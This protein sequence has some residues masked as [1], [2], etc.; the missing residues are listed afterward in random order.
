MLG[1][2]RKAGWSS[3]MTIEDL[4]RFN[5]GVHPTHSTHTQKLTELVVTP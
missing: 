3:L 5:G 2:S 4:A 1:S